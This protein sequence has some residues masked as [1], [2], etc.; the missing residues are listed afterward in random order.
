M[1]LA[2]LLAPCQ[3]SSF[4]LH[5]RDYSESLKKEGIPSFG[6]IHLDYISNGNPTSRLICLSCL[7]F[8]QVPHG[9][10]DLADLVVGLLGKLL[11][12]DACIE[13]M[14][15]Q[16]TFAGKLLTIC[17][18]SNCTWQLGWS[19]L[20]MAL[21]QKLL[22]ENFSTDPLNQLCTRQILCCTLISCASQVTRDTNGSE[23]MNEAQQTSSQCRQT[24]RL[25]RVMSVSR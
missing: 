5:L 20:G 2:L 17:I 8:S 21:Q 11:Q 13:Y 19:C 1:L 16:Y 24:G 7:K 23:M 12:N 15:G 3:P 4:L 14:F 25:K 18:S 9:H 22:Q 6:P 10:M